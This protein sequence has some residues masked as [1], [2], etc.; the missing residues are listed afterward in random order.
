MER[1]DQWPRVHSCVNDWCPEKR[2]ECERCD[3][4][5]AILRGHRE[6]EQSRAIRARA[7]DIVRDYEP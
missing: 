2:P 4:L 3:R 1:I 5:V 7:T 6:D